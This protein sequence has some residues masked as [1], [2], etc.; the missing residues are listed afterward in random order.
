MSPNVIKVFPAFYAWLLIVLQFC[1]LLIHFMFFFRLTR[2][3][4]FSLFGHLGF[5]VC[6][7]LELRNLKFVGAS[8]SFLP[9]GTS[10]WC[11]VEGLIRPITGHWAAP[12]DAKGGAGGFDYSERMSVALDCICQPKGSSRRALSGRYGGLH[13]TWTVCGP[14]RRLPVAQNSGHAKRFV[15]CKTSL[16]CILWPGGFV[17]EGFVIDF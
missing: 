2:I 8:S 6:Q 3:I 16:F 12:P 1:W 5:G 9:W 14:E 10:R 17:F 13:F 15:F 7:C 11:A 4:V